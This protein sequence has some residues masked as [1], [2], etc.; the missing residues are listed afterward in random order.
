VIERLLPL[1]V[2]FDDGGVSRNKEIKQLLIDAASL[3]IFWQFVG[4]GGRQYG[5][6]EKLDMMAGR[7]VGNCG[8]FSAGRPA[9][10]DEQALYDRLRGEFPEWLVAA[11]SKGIVF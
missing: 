2:Y 1:A 4:I 6:L 10:I 3:P 9:R 8:F 5:I 7:V 11:K